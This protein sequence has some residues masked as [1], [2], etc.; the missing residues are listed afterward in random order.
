MQTCEVCS[1][2][3]I[4]TVNLE[5]SCVSLS[6]TLKWHNFLHSGSKHHIPHLDSYNKQING[7]LNLLHVITPTSI[8]HKLKNTY[9]SC[10][11]VLYENWLRFPPTLK[12]A[13]NHYRWSL[14]DT[15]ETPLEE[16]CFLLFNV[17]LAKFDSNFVFRSVF[18]ALALGPFW[19]CM[20][21]T[22]PRKVM[23]T[24]QHM[25]SENLLAHALPHLGCV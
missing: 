8:D 20:E 12:K 6:C 18:E 23:E 19:I 25:F 3:E 21:R 24:F 7:S 9:L 16:S 4:I 5:V 1:E 10:S 17:C 2:L 13:L 14:E 22:Q 11:I 15:W